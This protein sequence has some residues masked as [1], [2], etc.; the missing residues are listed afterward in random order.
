M[1]QSNNILEELRELE[2]SLVQIQVQDIFQVPAGYFDNLATNMLHLVKTLDSTD[3]REEI[4]ILSPLLA[5]VLV[6][7]EYWKI[8][9][10]KS[11]APLKIEKQVQLIKEPAQ[12][13]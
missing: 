1:A 5:G 3:S 4:K 10:F 6:G 8:D 13:F 11:I 12:I 9:L 7:L 2:S